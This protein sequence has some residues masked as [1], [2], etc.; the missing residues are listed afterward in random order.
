[1]GSLRVSPR[2]IVG[3]LLTL[4]AF[5]APWVLS[6]RYQQVLLLTGV[7]ATVAVNG[8]GDDGW[9]FGNA[10]QF[11]DQAIGVGA[12]LLFSGIASLILF[13][14]VDRT[15]GLRVPEDDEDRGLDLTQHGEVA[16]RSTE[17]QSTRSHGGGA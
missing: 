9:L 11:V 8:A 17:V 16:Y 14:L 10:S 12:T 7:F 1:M 2:V 13:L 6:L 5:A 15:I 4:A 3:V